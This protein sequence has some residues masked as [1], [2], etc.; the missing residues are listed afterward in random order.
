MFDNISDT[1]DK[2]N[3]H[4]SLGMDSRWKCCLVRHAV[5][6]KPEKIL[7]LATGTADVPVRM[8]KAGLNNITGLDLSV[9]MLKNGQERLKE[10]GLENKIS[11][12]QGD[13]ENLPFAANEF[14][15]VTVSYGLR[16]YENL[17]KGLKE[18]YRVLK[19]GGT[20]IIL[21]TSV[22]Q[23][24]L[25]RKGYSLFTSRFMPLI[26]RLH[27]GDKA[28]YN[29]L[30]ESA[31]KFPCGE[32]LKIILEKVGFKNVMIDPQF[33]GAATIYKCLKLG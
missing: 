17:S 4:I 16:N 18:T 14:D 23:K 30:S 24:Y 13:S 10:E 33:F 9:G 3:K 7:D 32:D 27:S 26:G 8:A 2:T 1:Y 21:E 5:S 12:L 25:F 22:P 20:F 19:P 15:V 31:A 29:Y 11:L 28:S 6:A